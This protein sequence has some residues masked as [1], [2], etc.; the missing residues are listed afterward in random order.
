MQNKM[1][2]WLLCVV[3]T[4]NYIMKSFVG[5]SLDYQAGLIIKIVT[6]DLF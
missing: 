4:F 2:F 1:E 6:E 3:E 5:D